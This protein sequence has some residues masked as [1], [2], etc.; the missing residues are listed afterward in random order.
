MFPFNCILAKRFHRFDH[1]AIATDGESVYNPSASFSNCVTGRRRL[2]ARGVLELCDGINDE[3][4]AVLTPDP[5]RSLM[6]CKGVLQGIRAEIIAKGEDDDHTTY[7][8]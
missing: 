3:R 7:K 5:P 8:S 1:P 2:L 4:A 6:D